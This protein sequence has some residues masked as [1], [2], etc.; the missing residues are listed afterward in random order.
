M[1]EVKAGEPL[2]A[3]NGE[4]LLFTEEFAVRAGVSAATLRGYHSDA[5]ARR[6]RRKP[7]HFPAP[8]EYVRRVSIKSNEKPVT[9]QTPVWRESVVKGYVENRLGPGGRPVSKP[10][11]ATAS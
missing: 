7:A 8:T 5:R 9:A 2:Y 3:D 4:R 6:R 10:D 11:Q 1:R